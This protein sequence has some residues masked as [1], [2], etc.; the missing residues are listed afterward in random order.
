MYVLHVSLD[1]R[2]VGC[3][4]ALGLWKV[5]HEYTLSSSE[6]PRN[7]FEHRCQ[8]LDRNEMRRAVPAVV[9][10][11]FPGSSKMIFADFFTRMRFCETLSEN[12]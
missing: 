1:V 2:I 7:P 12:H 10:G 9:F 8:R 3:V 11:D 6:R 4:R 5:R